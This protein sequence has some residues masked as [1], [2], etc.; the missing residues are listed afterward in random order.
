MYNTGT[1]DGRTGSL[2]ANTAC[3]GSYTARISGSMGVRKYLRQ[4]IN[5]S[6]SE[7]DVYSLGGWAKANAIPEEE[8]CISAEIR[9]SDGT[10]YNYDSKGKLITV[11]K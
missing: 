7:G 8:F 11:N 10:S 6:G 9:Y 5:V 2:T 4:E 3:A 1:S